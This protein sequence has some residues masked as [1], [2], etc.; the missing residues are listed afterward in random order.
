M[1][2]K[3]FTLLTLFALCFLTACGGDDT[4]TEPDQEP[5][6]A[7]TMSLKVDDEFFELENVSA[8][9]YDTESYTYTIEG[10]TDNGT[11]Y[12]NLSLFTNSLEVG[13]YP[14]GLGV[15]ES[16][17]QFSSAFGSGFVTVAVS[18]SFTIDVND[19][20]NKR[21]EGTFNFEGFGGSTIVTEGVFNTLYEE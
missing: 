3:F 10:Y 5:E 19:T 4:I 2:T 18:G 13:T 11:I 15:S 14:V 8:V 7:N 17:A 16:S 21:I 1:D 9:L 6:I 12:K 20:E